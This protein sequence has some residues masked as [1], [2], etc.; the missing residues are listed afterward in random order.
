MKI[1]FLDSGIGGL[2]VL[3]EA[4]KVLPREDYI[5][6]ADTMN[7]PYGTKTRDEVKTT[8][9]DAAGFLSDKGIKALVVACNT[10]TSV[11]VS[12]LRNSFSFPVIGME[13]A[14]KPAVERVAETGKHVL[15]TATE[16]ALKEEKFQNL[17][18]R[19]DKY[20]IVDYIPLPGLVAFAEQFIFDGEA[21]E[22]YLGRELAAFNLSDCGSLVLGCT[23]FPHFRNVFKK[24]LP[25]SIEIIDGNESTVKHLKN[26]LEV[27]NLLDNTGTGNVEFYNSGTRLSDADIIGKY[28]KL[29]SA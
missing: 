23:H 2:T 3:K 21:V 28:K 15:V 9:K 20:N 29:L 16:L 8:V 13:P 7:A 26:I 1:G 18:A 11:A 12:E 17:V 5:Y 4:L 14:V 25:E 24:L 27:N 6:Y 22:N 10:A 19:V